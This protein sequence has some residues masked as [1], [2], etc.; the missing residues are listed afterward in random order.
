MS[1]GYD[2]FP[3][4][5]GF[6]NIHLNSLAIA[7]GYAQAWSLAKGWS[8]FLLGVPGFG[9]N[10]GKLKTE[11][12]FSPPFA[13]VYKLQGS[14]GFSFSN[15][16]FYGTLN[17]QS[18]FFWLNLGKENRFR[19]SIWKIKLSAGMRYKDRSGKKEK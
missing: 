9:F 5:S 14:A 8:I 4:A 19:Y 3:D 2:L 6:Q 10:T 7:G 17:F 18:H 12:W 1:E 16:R 11:E 15:K 13:P